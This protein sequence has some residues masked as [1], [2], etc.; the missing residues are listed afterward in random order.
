[1]LENQSVFR[2]GDSCINQ[3]LSITYETCQSFD[4]S[5]EVRAVFLDIFKA[6]GKVLHKSLVSNLK[7]NGISNK[8]LNLITDFFGLEN[9]GSYEMGNSLLGLALKQVCE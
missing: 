2:P 8:I 4:E 1:M 7:Q 5:L 3:H 9:N 6:L